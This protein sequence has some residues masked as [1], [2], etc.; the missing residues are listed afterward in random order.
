MQ[1]RKTVNYE[2]EVATVFDF[3]MFYIKIWKIGC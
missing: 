3:L 2:N 1:I